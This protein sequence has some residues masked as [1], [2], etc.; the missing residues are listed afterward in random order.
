M[1]VCSPA[2]PDVETIS[3]ILLDVQD[4]EG[5]ASS[6]KVNTIEVKTDCEQALSRAKCY[7]REL[8]RRYCDRQ[9]SAD[10]MKVAEGIAGELE[11]MGNT[12]QGAELKEAFITDSSTD[13]T[14]KHWAG[15][16]ATV[17]V[18]VVVGIST[19]V[20]CLGKGKH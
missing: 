5:L 1:I 19:C 8:V 6:I 20:W 12:R 10:P 11:R 4:W 9:Q 16:P 18:A 13:L 14:R 17:L 3:R 15:T 7:R 2:D